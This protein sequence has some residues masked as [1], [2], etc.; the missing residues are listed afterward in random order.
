MDHHKLLLFFHPQYV[1]DI[2]VSEDAFLHIN[3]AIQSY[4]LSLVPHGE[5]QIYDSI[6]LEKAYSQEPQA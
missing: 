1:E 2:L 6:E 3:L 5:N 4:D